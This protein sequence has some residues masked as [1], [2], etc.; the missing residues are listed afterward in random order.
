MRTL[1]IRFDGPPGPQAGRFVE[2][3]DEKGRSVTVGQWRQDGPYWLLV[4]DVCSREEPMS[5]ERI[6]RLIGRH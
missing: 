6:D 5:Q 4:I 3:E 1:Q 2:V